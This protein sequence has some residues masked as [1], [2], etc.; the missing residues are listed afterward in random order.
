MTN[1]DASDLAELAKQIADISTL[2]GE[3]VL[4]SGQVSNR[5][6]DKYRFEA[7]PA[8]LKPLA[9]AMSTLLPSDTE[10]VAGLEL[11]GVPLAT[12]ISMETGLPAAFVRKEA[13]TYGTCR[14]LEGQDVAG[15]RVT[16]IE[17]VITSGGAVADAYRL[18][19]DEG[20]DILAVVCAIWRGDGSPH[21]QTCPS[22]PVLPVFMR[23][24]LERAG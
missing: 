17:D 15:R 24:D 10:I 23:G 7:M 16:F 19:S 8:L 6:F 2:E 12:A 3:F 11:G 21:I 14:A 13:K 20:A 9:Q 22:L 18:V 1:K 5:Y 4:R